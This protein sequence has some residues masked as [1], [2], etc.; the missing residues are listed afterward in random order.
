MEPDISRQAWIKKQV[1]SA[2]VDLMSF[3]KTSIY[4]GDQFR[5]YLGGLDDGKMGK[6]TCC[7]PHYISMVPRDA[8]KNLQGDFQKLRQSQE[9]ARAKGFDI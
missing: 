1:K 8:N 7:Y 2:T 3:D 6:R 5:L 4:Y 9:S